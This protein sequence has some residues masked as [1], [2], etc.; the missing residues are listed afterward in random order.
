MTKAKL[1]IASRAVAYY[2]QSLNGAPTTS[3]GMPALT[4][5][6]TDWMTYEPWIS[7]NAWTQ[8]AK[9]YQHQIIPQANMAAKT[10]LVMCGGTTDI[11]QGRTGALTYAD[12]Q[13]IAVAAKAAGWDFVV[14]CTLTPSVS[15]TAGAL[16]TERLALN[17]LITTNSGGTFDGF[18]EHSTSPLND[19]TNT[20]YY[21]DGIHWTTTGASTAAG[22]VVPALTATLI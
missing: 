5:A 12:M 1:Y 8:F 6:A 7:G 11:V 20:T 2:G 21:S 22:L 10:C 14:A 13:T 19:H 9:W 18:A 15:I 4:R 16:E 3:N 17:T